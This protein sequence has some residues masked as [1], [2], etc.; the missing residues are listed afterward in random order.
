ALLTAR[1]AI[2][3]CRGLRGDHDI[4]LRTAPT[5]KHFLAHN[6]E[7]NRDTTSSSVRP[8]VLQEND[9]RPFRE[10][11][12]AGAA[13]GLPT[14]FNLVNGRTTHVSP[15]LAPARSWSDEELLICSDAWAP[16]NLVDTEHYFGDHATSHAAALR[17]GL[18][19]FTDH[20]GDG[21][22]TTGH[23]AAA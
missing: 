15:H 4:Y 3:F 2:A 11:I 12:E 1:M 19:S 10:P 16:S 21:A 8:R 5:L 6:N 20:D 23:V 13:T 18:D 17:A 22:F 14:A 9:A 7:A